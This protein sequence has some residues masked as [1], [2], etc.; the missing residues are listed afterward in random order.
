MTEYYFVT[1]NMSVGYDRKP[2]IES[3]E[4]R[5]KKGEILTLIG[6]N[7]AGKSTILKSI[8]RQLNELIADYHMD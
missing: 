2:L 5:L 3:M 6:P 1:E 7:G 4:I 8:A